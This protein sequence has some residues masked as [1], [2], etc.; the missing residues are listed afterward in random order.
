M[1]DMVRPK[2]ERT[3]T[4]SDLRRCG[5]ADIFFDTFFNLD[6]F[7]EHEQRDPFANV[8][9]HFLIFVALLACTQIRLNIL[10]RIS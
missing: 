9:V 7:L 5:M 1:F 4:L 2:V 6:K 3:I 10:A 8:K